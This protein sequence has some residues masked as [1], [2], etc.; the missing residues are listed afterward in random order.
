MAIRYDDSL[1]D[2]IR[3]T[4]KNYQAKRKRVISKGGELLPD[5]AYVS[6][7]LTE[8]TDRR[9]LLRDLKKLQR[10]SQLGA[11]EVVDLESGQ[12]VTR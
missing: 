1:R 12:R 4:V 2:E 7:F 3:R 9:T 5:P 10:Y 6:T 11:E 8:Y